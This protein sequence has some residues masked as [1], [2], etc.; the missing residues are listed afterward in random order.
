VGWAG[1]GGG[2]GWGLPRYNFVPKIARI[3][4]FYRLT[5]P[6]RSIPIDNS[7]EFRNEREPGP[8][9]AVPSPTEIARGVGL[10]VAELGRGHGPHQVGT[11]ESRSWEMGRVVPP[12][13]GA[14]PDTL[15]T[16]CLLVFAWHAEPSYP[17]VVAANRDE[18]LDRPAHSLC[19]L[20]EHDPRV[21]GGR[22]DMAGGTWLAVNEHGV[23]V[24]LT[25]RPSPGGRD[26]TKRSRGELPLMVADHDTADEGVAALLRSVRP[27]QYNPAWLLIGDRESLYYIEL[28]NEQPP[29]LERLS[30]GIHVLE[31]VALG[32]SSLKADRVRSQLS[33]AALEGTPL[34]SA[35][36]SALVDHTVPSIDTAADR[37][38]GAQARPPATLASC[39]HTDDY[40]TRS[41]AL[42]MVGSDP[43]RQ[44]EM[45]V[46]DGPPCVTPFVDVGRR[47]A[48]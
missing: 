3:I 33:A 16:M 20:R 35:M 29:S 22:D 10:A 45:M 14:V 39:V 23:V 43:G 30:P 13:F 40:G 31:N 41:A 25:N 28:D 46:A 24:G 37:N 44:P 5:G 32:Q 7:V 12:G 19:V 36:Q 34:W 47:W 6:I 9:S 42:I 48:A 4:E 21:L 17:L 15:T 1:L 8:P 27:G 38:D 18:R 2:V 11:G 26:V